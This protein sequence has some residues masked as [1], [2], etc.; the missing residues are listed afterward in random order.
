MET[1]TSIDVKSYK[2]VM[3][4][5]ANVTDLAV[6][7][8]TV[9]MAKADGEFSLIIY[10]R[11]GESFSINR[12]GRKTTNFPALN[13]LIFALSKSEVR[14]AKL[15]VEMYAMENGVP[16]ML[17]KYI[18][19]L[20]G[21]VAGT[22]EKIFIGVWDIYSINGR[23]INESHKWKLEE[24]QTWVEGCRWVHVLP[25]SEPRTIAALKRVWHEF[26]EEMGYEG[27][28]C[29]TRSGIFKIKPL[30]DM[31]AVIIGINK[32]ELLRDQL[33]TSLKLGLLNKNGSIV[34]IGDVASGITFPLRQALWKLMDWKVGEDNDTIFVKPRVIC[35]LQFN[36][37]YP[38]TNNRVF[39]FDGGFEETGK[40]TLIRLRHPRLL[41]FRDDKTV[42]LEDIGLNQVPEGVRGNGN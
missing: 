23:K 28:V 33:V 37:I 39:K 10:N 27:L 36:D 40:Q 13:E 17:P 32:R 12:Y 20:K 11:E 34:E 31:D 35:K 19:F 9:V 30:I 26:V 29:R 42:C 21:H 2:P 16:L 6:D 38:E 8:Q 41:G 18:H 24:A 3:K 25:W 7:N 1:D 4:T 14:T 5:L 15:L 22:L